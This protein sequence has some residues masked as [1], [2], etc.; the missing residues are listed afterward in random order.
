MGPPRFHAEGGIRKAAFL[1][2]GLTIL[3]SSTDGTTRL[4]DVAT[5]KTLGPPLSRNGASPVAC[6]PDGRMV[7]VADRHGRVS[8]WEM[9]RPLAGTVDGVRLWVEVHTGMELNDQEEIR[10]LSPDALAERR[11]RLEELEGMPVP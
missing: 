10:P 1:P 8:L 7:A 5:G 4:W 3:I 2:D 9:P 11:R 6:A